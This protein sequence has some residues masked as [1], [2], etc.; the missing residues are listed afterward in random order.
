MKETIRLFDQDS[1]AR[2][3]R[4][5][6]IFCEALKEGKFRIVLEETLFF[7]ES[8]GQSS[9]RGCLNE[10]KVTDVQIEEGI[11]YHFTDGAL[12]E[13]KMAEG[14]ICWEHRFSNM[15][16]HSGEHIFS[17]TVNR[18]FGLNNVGFHL[19]D[20]IMTM[21]FD[22]ILTD[23]QLERVEW[24]ANRAITE[25]IEVQVSYPDPKELK[26][27]DYR[28]KIEIEGQVRIVT[29]PGYDVC[30]CCAPHVKRTGEIGMIKIMTVQNHKGGIRV[31]I[32]CGFR[33]LEAFREKNRI[34][35][36]LTGMLSTSQG[37]L[38]IQMEKQRNK[39]YALK[40][41][42][43]EAKKKLMEYRIAE[44]SSDQTNILLF[45]KDLET[46]VVRNTVNVLVE[47]HSGICGI[48]VEKEEGGYQYILGSRNIDCKKAAALLR[49]KLGAKGGGSERMIQG[50]VEA[51]KEAIEE[52][53]YGGL[54]DEYS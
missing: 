28:S 14:E 44:L 32:L 21:D 41:R 31:S 2:S 3:F 45:E 30:A 29:I 17:G 23:E 36:A 22:G 39:I 25:N 1:Y 4:S 49:N 12:E 6:V 13:G 42:L 24:E 48:F 15:Q 8:G 51:S 9:D 53:L 11:I 43:A 20:Q 33:A 50:L 54:R 7:P 37:T 27:L 38:P 19:S 52:E 34:L 18:L 5:K 16:Q 26:T 10:V 40:G 46:E 47:R 35:S